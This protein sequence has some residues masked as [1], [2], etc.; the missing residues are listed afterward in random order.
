MPYNPDIEFKIDEAVLG[1]YELTKKK[2]FGGICY[3]LNNN[4]CCGVYKDYL[5]VRVGNPK[6]AENYLKND[7]IVPFDITGKK[8][9]RLDNGKH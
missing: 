5:I 2:M 6:K 7:L 9:E 8:N 1:H 3:L 4:M